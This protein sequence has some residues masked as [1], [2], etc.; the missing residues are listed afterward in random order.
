M[1]LDH[2]AESVRPAGTSTARVLLVLPT[3]G[4]RPELLRRTLDSLLHQAGEPADVVV[5]APVDATAVRQELADRV[6]EGYPIRVIDDPGRGLAAAV[7]AGFR[8]AGPGHRYGNW[9]GEDDVLLPGALR[10]ACAEL[11]EHPDAVLVYGD[12]QHV[13]SDGEYLFTTR[14]GLRP[15]WL[16]TWGP[17]LLSQPAVLFRLDALVRVGFLD[18]GLRH[19]MD[20]DLLLK[21]RRDGRFVA[22]NRA[23]AG[24]H[25]TDAPVDAAR[26][27]F[28]HREVEL[29]RRRYLPAAVRA[30][31]GWWEAPVRLISQHP[32]HQLQR[33]AGWLPS[34]R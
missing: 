9:I 1:S 14:A 17:D 10:V 26:R 8:T 21:L 3:T 32:R 18:E 13:D 31:A 33:T 30:R 25:R 4:R 16:M 2:L 20:L 24:F 27:A 6:A 29:V 12:C 22:S 34:P 7:N 28:A 23:L 19:A 15:D 5:I 11:D